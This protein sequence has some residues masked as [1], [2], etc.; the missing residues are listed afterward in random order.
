[1]GCRKRMSALWVEIGVFKVT[2]QR[3]VYLA[4]TTRIRKWMRGTILLKNWK[5]KYH[6]VGNTNNIRDIKRTKDS[7][8]NEEK[9]IGTSDLNDLCEK[10]QKIFDELQ[11]VMNKE[12]TRRLISTKG[13]CSIC[14]GKQ[15]LLTVGLILKIQEILIY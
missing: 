5:Q 9:T 3:L 7:A 2:E 15:I 6:A 1:M 13:S 12:I 14:L 8:I 10:G 4:D 11:K